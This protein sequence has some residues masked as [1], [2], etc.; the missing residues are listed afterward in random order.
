[1]QTGARAALVVCLLLA[2]C[3]MSVTPALAQQTH[4]GPGYEE[5]AAA[6]ERVAR[7]G[8]SRTTLSNLGVVY[9]N[10]DALDE[11][12]EATFARHEFFWD[13]REPLG[14]IGGRHHRTPRSFESSSRIVFVDRH[15]QAIGLG[16]RVWTM[17]K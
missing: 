15:D 10:L 3:A 8:L 1:M 4:E 9:E 16:T 5:R 12:L 14:A 2:V 13:G 11:A 17:W 7:D 6:L